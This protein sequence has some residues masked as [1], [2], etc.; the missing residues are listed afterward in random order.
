MKRSLRLS[1]YLARSHGALVIVIVVLLLGTLQ[2]IVR[3]LALMSEIRDQ[4]FS[5][6]DSEE[7][8]HRSAW[9]VELALR[10]GRETCAEAGGET[11]IRSALERARSDLREQIAEMGAGAPA[12]LGNAVK[13]YAA[14]SDEALSGTTCAFLSRPT[15]D[16]LRTKLDA[17][18]TNVWIRRLYD[19]HGEIKAREEGMR[20]IGLMTVVLGVSVA[21]SAAV[22][23]TVIARNTAR[24]VTEPVARLARAATRLGEGQ[25]EPI[26]EEDEPAEVG[27]LWRDID[28]LR[29]RLLESDR[30]KSAFLASVSHEL[31]T[32]LGRLREALALLTDGTCGPLNE[33]QARVG[34][35]ASRACEREVRLVNALLDLSRLRAGEPLK[36]RSGCDVDKIIADAVADER[37]DAEE[38]KVVVELEATGTVPTAALDPALLERAVANLVRNA[39]SVSPP[40]QVVRVERKIETDP[41]GHRKIL[42]DVSDAGPGLPQSVRDGMFRPFGAAPVPGTSRPVGIGIGLSLASDVARAHGG[43]L[44]TIRSGPDGTTL[45]VEIPAQPSDGAS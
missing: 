36:R 23:A 14:L 37:A 45:R 28:R 12:E 29:Q 16:V 1:T 44:T 39:V 10:Y 26:P 22:A 7:E 34:S 40:N 6:L 17:D 30:V 18:L 31:R 2:G 4:H 25:F 32:P 8:L 38:R 35:I 15:T 41:S 43:G 33:R 27:E 42:I 9:A 11:K 3:M 24:R 5:R 19:L 21:I 20:R 13:G